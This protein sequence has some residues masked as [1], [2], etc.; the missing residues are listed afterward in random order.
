MF[1]VNQILVYL[2][3]KPISELMF[4]IFAF[5][6]PFQLRYIF[7]FQDSYIDWS[8]NYH[9]ALY[10]YLTDIL[11]IGFM[12][13]WLVFDRELLKT[14]LVIFFAILSGFFAMFHVKQWD[15]LLYNTLK[16]SQFWFIIL[17][18]RSK[19]HL[20]KPAIWATIIAG[21]IQ[22]L[23]AVLQFHMEHGL[24][25]WFLGEFVPGINELGTATLSS[26]GEKMLRAY[27]TMPHPNVLGG[28]LAISI[29]LLLYVSRG[30]WS[31]WKVLGV[32]CATFLLSWGLLVSFSRSAWLA[33]MVGSLIFLLGLIKSKDYKM[34]YSWAI[35]LVV[36]C[37]TLGLIYNSYVFP[38]S[39]DIG[40]DSQA[41]VYRHNFNQM[42]WKAFAE[43]PLFGQGL[44][45]Y[46]PYLQSQ[47]DL[48]P[49]EHQPPHNI[50]I[51]TLAE[52]GLVGLILTIFALYSLGFTWN[53]Q[54]NSFILS[55]FSQLII[56]GSFDH[57]LITIQQGKLL[58][59]ICL[60]LILIQL[61]NVS[62][63][64][65]HFTKVV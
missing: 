44:G 21:L 34:A 14:D 5:C 41:Y 24:G 25:L 61:K 63:D 2:R 56:L 19:P 45:Q 27:G 39:A 16:F 11:F 35:F 4:L 47:Y 59:G 53:N 26:N 15:L 36:S 7:N 3:K 31:K 60:G 30:T 52:I 40:L 46:V 32:S 54:L 57:Y 42:G 48:E 10:I 33:A 20:L 49:W 9:L 43:H 62:Q 65:K 51:L 1:H 8:F 29:V 37:V 13:P 18:L 55:L 64:V 23:I 58:L 6:L 50:G 38:R 12:I 28:F 22:A 17:F